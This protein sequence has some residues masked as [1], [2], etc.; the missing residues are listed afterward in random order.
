MVALI[1]V[2]PKQ[3]PCRSSRNR[4]T[5]LSIVRFVGLE[6]ARHMEYFTAAIRRDG[7]KSKKEKS[8]NWLIKKR[9]RSFMS[10][11]WRKRKIIR[12]SNNTG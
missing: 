2:I 9:E 6:V 11:V 1:Q 3:G 5:E 7:K 10:C 8:L 4:G 12:Y